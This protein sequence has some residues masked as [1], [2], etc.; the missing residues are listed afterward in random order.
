MPTPNI[1]I[2]NTYESEIWKQYEGERNNTILN[3]TL[4]E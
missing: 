2:Y 3:I 1:Y 4:L